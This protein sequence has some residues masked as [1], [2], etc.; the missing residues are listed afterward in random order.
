MA[1]NNEKSSQADNIT[2]SGGG[3]YSLATAGAK[4]VIDHA[5][6]LVLDALKSIPSPQSHWSFSDMGCADG[7]TSL[8]LWRKVAGAV[9][10]HSDADM[11]VTYSDQP[12][13]DFNALVRI[14]HGLTD[15]TT[16]RH[17]QSH[18]HL[19]ESGSSFYEPIVPKNTLDLG[20]SATA[21]H[22][23]SRKPCDIP[24]HVHMVGASG[25]VL[26]QFEQ[27]AQD[28]WQTILLHR[29]RE[30]KPGGK[31]VLANF[32]RDSNGYYLG[33][34]GGEN[35]FDNF[36]H[37]WCEFRDKGLITPDEYV[38]MTLPQYYNTVEE[39]SRPFNDAGSAVMKAGLRL[40]HIETGIIKCP[41]ARDFM[42]HKDATKFAKA[43]IP[44]I[45]SWNESIYFGGLSTERSDEARRNL[46]E[47]YYSTY[48]ARVAANPEGHA[49]DYVHAY[50]TIS[51]IDD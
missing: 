13:N 7:G 44:T 6:P 40:E 39:F 19:F 29:A 18:V 8:D 4:D 48:E 9:R 1:D 28:D 37:L 23:L 35:M 31:L 42:Q 47:R 38:A 20:F 46:I 3:V 11:Q 21:M 12:R 43:F 49:M 41:Y 33:N 24:D 27:Q 50:I 34:T 10:R 26:Q 36:N 22:W 5:T 51:K 16:Y 15:F 25:D 45:R 32:C 17:E 30:L 14:L 2:M